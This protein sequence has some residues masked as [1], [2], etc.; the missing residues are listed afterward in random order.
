L[1]DDLPAEAWQTLTRPP[2]YP[3]Q[4]E[5]RRRPENVKE[6]I[7]VE[8]EFKNVRLVREKVAEFA[9]RPTACRQSYRLIVVRKNLSV[10]KGECVLFEDYR[11]FFYI[12]ND[13]RRSAVETVFA[14]N[15]RC[16]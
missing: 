12:T 1:A 13:R 5:P 3:V 2:R 7:V 15:D 16:N 14:A 6:P 4:T 11:Y 8:R 9:Y 10:E